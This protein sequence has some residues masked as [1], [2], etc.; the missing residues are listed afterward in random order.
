[1]IYC[2]L[3]SSRSCS[4]RRLKTLWSRPLF[5]FGR[6]RN[7]C[8][9]HR[10]RSSRSQATVRSRIYDM[11]RRS[12]KTITQCEALDQ[13]RLGW[14]ECDGGIKAVDTE[15]ESVQ[16]RD[17]ESS[18]TRR[19]RRISSHYVHTRAVPTESDI[20]LFNRTFYTHNI[21]STH[22]KHATSHK[23]N[24]PFIHYATIHT[25]ITTDQRTSLLQITQPSCNQSAG[26][27]CE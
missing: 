25:S 17:S 4:I 3:S 1:M 6:N 7:H 15:S 16:S 12:D 20:I 13:Q 2:R 23:I 24:Q 18:L 9:S 14:Q 26:D 21:K 27:Y 8:K 11:E 10:I 22:Q 5:K 19:R